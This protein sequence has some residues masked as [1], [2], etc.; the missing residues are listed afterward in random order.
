MCLLVKCVKSGDGFLEGEIYPILGYRRSEAYI[1][2]YAFYDG[3]VPPI[4][5]YS[6]NGC[7]GY[8]GDCNEEDCPEF[9]LYADINDDGIRYRVNNE[10]YFI[11]SVLG[12]L[13]NVR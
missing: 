7:G 5:L 1:A 12:G 11:G 13:F 4:C 3:E 6:Q 8:I 9:E 2:R 10:W